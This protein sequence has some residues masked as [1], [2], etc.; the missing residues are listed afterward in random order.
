MASTFRRA[1]L[2]VQLSRRAGRSHTP[3]VAGTDAYDLHFV[4]L[5]VGALVQQFYSP[6]VN[7]TF[8]CTVCRPDEL[9]LVTWEL[10]F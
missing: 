9:S 10:G 7:M 1:S 3:N 5:S 6:E 2:C 4:Y 8:L